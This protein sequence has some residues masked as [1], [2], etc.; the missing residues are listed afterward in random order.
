MSLECRL[1]CQGRLSPGGV[2]RGGS[3]DICELQATP[4]T[5]FRG[6]EESAPGGPRIRQKKHESLCA[7]ENALRT[8]DLERTPPSRTDLS[9]RTSLRGLRDHNS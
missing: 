8:H 3:S 6:A 4:P 7:P 2:L 9:Q 1:F 5:I